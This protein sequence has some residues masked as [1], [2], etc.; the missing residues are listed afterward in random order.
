MKI[1][2][3]ILLVL[4]SNVNTINKL[5]ILHNIHVNFFVSTLLALYL[6]NAHPCFFFIFHQ[7]VRKPFKFINDVLQTK[8]SL[9]N[10]SH[11]PS[12]L[13]LFVYSFLA[14]AWENAQ[15]I[16]LQISMSIYIN[17]FSYLVRNE[18]AKI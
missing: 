13:S 16:S 14:I 18:T 15:T 12:F 5:T 4:C 10:E 7:V 17:I 11:F 9:V 1:L 8:E 6:F 3:F 2:L